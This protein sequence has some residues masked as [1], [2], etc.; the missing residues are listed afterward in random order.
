MQHLIRSRVP[1]GTM[2]GNLPP[3]PRTGTV[4]EQFP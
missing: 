4:K 2:A 3:R 1:H